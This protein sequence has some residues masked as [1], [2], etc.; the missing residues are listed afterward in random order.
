MRSTV[1]SCALAALA[2]L[3]LGGGAL[4]RAEYVQQG[5]LLTY[6]NADIAPTQL[7]RTGLRPVRLTLATSFERLDGADV[8]ALRTMTVRLARGGVMQ[9]RGLARCP[10][11]RLVQR[12]SDLALR[13]CGGALVG[14]G[15]VTTALRFPDGKRQRSRS[16]LLL[17]NGGP[18]RLLMHI[19]VTEPLEGVFV[20]PV[21]V[22][23]TRG[24][25]G[26]ELRVAFPRIGAGYGR[27]TGFRMKLERTYRRRGALRSY[28]LGGCP[29]PRGLNR[30]AFELARAEFRFAGAPRL[31]GSSFA[32]CR[33]V[34][35]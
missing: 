23:R 32:V 35:R 24:L 31:V 29:A 4:S 34:G 12:A 7:P 20:L 3:L 27:V 10:P 16:R 30:L 21:E 15:D 5:K 17:F 1:W 8:P 33:A 22:R 19:H 28:L 26:T 13:A 9:S 18:R 25:F 6:F 2:L 11:A 14:E